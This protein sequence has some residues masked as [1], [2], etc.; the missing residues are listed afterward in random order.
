MIKVYDNTEIKNLKDTENTEWDT[1]TVVH[2]LEIVWYV[3]KRWY[4]TALL[5]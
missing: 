2:E 5:L 1:V 3:A 4:C